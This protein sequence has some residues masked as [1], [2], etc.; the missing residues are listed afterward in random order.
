MIRYFMKEYILVFNCLNNGSEFVKSSV[1]IVFA[2]N[3][4]GNKGFGL[5]SISS[6]INVR[7]VTSI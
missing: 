1:I 4:F 7:H 5:V 2:F 3:F 6:L